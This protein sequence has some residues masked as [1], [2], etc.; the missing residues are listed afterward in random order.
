MVS[1]LKKSLICIVIILAISQGLLAQGSDASP[2]NY[3]RVA[4]MQD[5]PSLRIKVEGSY[6]LVNPLNNEII[7]T[8]KNLNTT[9]TV[10][11]DNLSLGNIKPRAGRILIRVVETGSIVIDGRRFRGDIQLVKKD[12]SHLLAINQID[13]ED[14]VKGILYHESSHYWPMEALKAQ[15]VACRTYALY[16]MQKNKLKDFDLTSDIYSQV[17]GG[18]TSER[19][20]TNRAVL[21]TGGEMLLY[22]GKIFPAYYHATCAGFTEDASWLWNIDVPALKGV[23][24]KFCKD[25]PHFNWHEVLTLDELKEKLGSSGYNIKKIKN[26]IILGHNISGRITDLKITSDN[27]NLVI[28]AKDFRNIIGPNVIRSTNFNVG[29]VG[30]DVVFEGIGWGHGVGLCQWGAYFMAKQ[31]YNYKQILEY[32]YPGSEIK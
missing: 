18:R 23:A 30:N 3:V 9:A 10:H 32:Y 25:S 4:I 13:L 27:G 28:P 7:Y 2:K 8:G 17:Y 14:Y 31:G 16:Q 6:E 21:E 15:A 24:C 26:I 1:P 22:Q 20:R 5:A 29:V 12:N 11:K 19:Y